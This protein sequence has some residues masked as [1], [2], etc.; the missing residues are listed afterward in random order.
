MSIRKGQPA[1]GSGSCRPPSMSSRFVGLY[2]PEVS[3][4]NVSAGPVSSNVR[5]TLLA[6]VLRGSHIGHEDHGLAQRAD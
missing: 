2:V 5:F 1:R 3:A 4:A 6:G